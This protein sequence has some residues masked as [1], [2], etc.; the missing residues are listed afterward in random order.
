MKRRSFLGLLVIFLMAVVGLIR[1]IKHLE[2][3]KGQQQ[4]L[5]LDDDDFS[6]DFEIEV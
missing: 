5:I 6:A 3:Q 1:F 4:Q 2:A